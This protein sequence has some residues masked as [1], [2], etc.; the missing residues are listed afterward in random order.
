MHCELEMRDNQLKQYAAIYDKAI[1]KLRKD[2]DDKS[3]FELRDMTTHR[4]LCHV[5]IAL[6]LNQFY[7]EKIAF[8]KKKSLES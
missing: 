1:S 8:T 3:K 2:F 7:H 4:R 6:D 5:T